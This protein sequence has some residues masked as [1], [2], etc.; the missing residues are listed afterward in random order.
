MDVASAGLRGPYPDTR[1]R[2][3][4]TALHAPLVERALELPFDIYAGGCP[5]PT[6]S[7]LNP[8]P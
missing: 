4:A 1:I 5:A 8:N 6:P 2:L 7:T 3:R